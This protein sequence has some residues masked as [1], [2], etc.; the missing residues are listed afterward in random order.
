MNVK[1]MAVVLEQLRERLKYQATAQI[2]ELTPKDCRELLV[3]VDWIEALQMNAIFRPSRRE[4]VYSLEES[5]SPGGDVRW[6]AVLLEQAGGSRT[7][8]GDGPIPSELRSAFS[9]GLP[10][11]W[12]WEGGAL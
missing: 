11:F 6:S 9:K 12:R 2:C 5:S 7:V 10:I 4:L 1:M 8:K 3:L